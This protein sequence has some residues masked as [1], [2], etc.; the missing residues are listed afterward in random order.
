MEKAIEEKIFLFQKHE[1]VGDYADG[2]AI[3]KYHFG[4]EEEYEKALQVFRGEISHM[5]RRIAICELNKIIDNINPNHVGDM[6]RLYIY[7]I[8]LRVILLIIIRIKKISMFG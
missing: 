3:G 1:E 6:V 5:K 8:P 7:S 4:D 2:F